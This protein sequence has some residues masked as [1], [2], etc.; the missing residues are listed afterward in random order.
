MRADLAGRYFFCGEQA[1][2]VVYFGEDGSIF[3]KS[4]IR[5]AVGAKD[6][7]D[8]ALLCY[9]FG[10]IRADARKDDKA[11]AYVLAQTKQQRCACETAN[12]S[13]RCCLKDFPRSDSPD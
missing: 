6:A 8:E 4:D 11:R 2:D 12:P 9:C 13:G 7:S 3:V 5:T 1:C 10:V